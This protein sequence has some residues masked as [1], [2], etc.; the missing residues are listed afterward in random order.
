MAARMRYLVAA[1]LLS[2]CYI[3]N[4]EPLT[5]DAGADLATPLQSPEPD[6]ALPA[7]CPMAFQSPPYCFAGPQGTASSC[8]PCSNLGEICHYFEA[9]LICAGD[10]Q[11][12]CYWAGGLSGGCKHGDGGT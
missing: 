7:D 10:H 5:R 1:L 8:G 4:P 2:G 12:R 11:W 6:L 3:G 9:D